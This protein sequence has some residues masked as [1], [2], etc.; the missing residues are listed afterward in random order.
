MRLLTFVDKLNMN[1]FRFQACLGWVILVAPLAACTADVEPA[2]GTAETALLEGRSIAVAVRDPALGTL[3]PLRLM[4]DGTSPE[5]AAF[6]SALHTWCDDQIVSRYIDVDP[7]SDVGSCAARAARDQQV[8]LCMAYRT[9]EL[10]EALAPTDVFAL[11]AKTWT[12]RVRRP[13]DAIGDDAELGLHRFTV[14]VFGASDAGSAALL[15]VHYTQDS[16]VHAAGAYGANGCAIGEL[17]ATVPTADDGR[18]TLGFVLASATN[19]G[20]DL[21]LDAAGKAEASLGAAAAARLANDRDESR[22]RIESWRGRHDSRLEIL[23]MWTGAPDA[24]FEPDTTAPP[25]GALIESLLVT[26]GRLPVVTRAMATPS[27]QASEELLRFTRIDPRIWKSV[28]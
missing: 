7:V 14:P 18:T 28:V 19:E 21:L 4:I 2:S 16:I 17:R 5:W 22:A 13:G 10:S 23:D 24:L 11:D 26:E 3:A 15:A 6:D 8:S 9:L 25:D 27:L 20:I 1:R 12:F